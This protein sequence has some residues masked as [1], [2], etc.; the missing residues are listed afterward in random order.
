MK[1]LILEKSYD[2]FYTSRSG[3]A[4]VCAYINR[5]RD[6]WRQMGRLAG[7]S[8]QIAQINILHY[9]LGL[10]CWA[11]A[12]NNALPVYGTTSISRWP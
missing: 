9:D 7:S 4:L 3:L 6:L 1:R 2:G 11:R 8:G 5:Y 12:I 10:L